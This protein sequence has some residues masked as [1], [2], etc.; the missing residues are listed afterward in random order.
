MI[1]RPNLY[2]WPPT[3]EKNRV[4]FDNLVSIWKCKIIP[5][6]Y[7]MADIFPR[8]EIFSISPNE[9]KPRIFFPHLSKQRSA[10]RSKKTPE[11]K[12]LLFVGKNESCSFFWK[13]RLKL[14][15]RRDRNFHVRH[16]DAEQNYGQMLQKLELPRKQA[17]KV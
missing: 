8:N 9:G 6:R 2:H 5:A 4:C 14:K 15:F 10:A 12:K 16:L 7:F 11:L 17:N 1:N 3:T 13:S